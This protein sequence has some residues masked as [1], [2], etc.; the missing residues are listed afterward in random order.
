MLQAQA[1]NIFSSRATESELFGEVG[2][3]HEK[4]AMKSHYLDMLLVVEE[5]QGCEIHGGVIL[6]KG[7]VR[8]RFVPER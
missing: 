5:L 7:R 8:V 1:S 6:H 3:M 2:A 4:R